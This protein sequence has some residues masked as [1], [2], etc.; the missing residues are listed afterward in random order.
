MSSNNELNNALQKLESNYFPFD[1]LPYFRNDDIWWYFLS[2]PYNLSL[3]ELSALK[4]ARFYTSFGKYEYVSETPIVKK[5]CCCWVLPI[6][7]TPNKVFLVDK[8]KK[9]V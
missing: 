1:F 4:N 5:T 3:P 7:I 2:P 6:F 9:N 8:Y